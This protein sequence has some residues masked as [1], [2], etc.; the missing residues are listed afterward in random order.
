MAQPQGYVGL[1]FPKHVCL[2]QKA[3]YG[4][5]QALRAWFERFTTQ[6]LHIGFTTLN[7][8]CNLFILKHGSYMVFL[9]LYVDDII[10]TGNNQSFISSLIQLLSSDFDLKDLC[11]LH[12]FLGLQIDYTSFGLFVHQSKYASDLLRKFAEVDCKPCKTPCSPNQHL[13]PNDSPL[14]SNPTSYRSLVGALQYL[15]FTRLDLSFATQQSCQ[16][17]SNPTQNHL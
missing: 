12:Y 13:L 3:F 10:I 6:L 16:Y 14:L 7:A 4:L 9:L 5:R 15:T 17:M 8:D 2:L 1:A 11:L